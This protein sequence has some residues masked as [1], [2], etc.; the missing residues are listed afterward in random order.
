MDMTWNAR[1]RE[2]RARYVEFGNENVAPGS[3]ERDKS[4]GFDI[5]V[6][7]LLAERGFWRIGVPRDLGGDGGDLSD[8]CAALE[9]LAFGSRDCGFLLSVGAHGS[10][11]QLLLKFGT[12]QQC[13]AI[14]PRLM[15]GDVGATA[16]TEETGGSHVTGVRTLAE[17]TSDGTFRLTGRKCHITN[18]PVADIALIVGRVADVGKRDITLFLIDTGQEG[19]ELGGHEDLIGLRTSPLGPITMNDVRIDAD[20]IV[21]GIGNGLDILYWTLALDR[22]CFGIIAAG[23]IASLVPMAVDRA[24]SRKAFGVVLA[25]HQYIQEKIVQMKVSAETARAL[26]YATLTA[27]QHDDPAAGLLASCVK[28]VSANG[29]VSS[30]LELVQ[31]FGHLGCDKDF[32]V[33]RQL[34]DATVFRIAGGTDEMQKKNIFAQVLAAHSAENPAA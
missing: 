32:G 6:W 25:E 20:R 16:A 3:S 10:L 18:A 15:S 11:I 1:Q 31:L 19:V 4:S 33:E 13:E 5:G 23:H 8:F 21:G 9:G 27:L 17:R 34:R 12:R 24:T 14:L 2:I 26:S 28:L 30:G 22:M 7:K 29:A